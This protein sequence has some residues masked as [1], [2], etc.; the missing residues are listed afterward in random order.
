V[1]QDIVF[2]VGATVSLYADRPIFTV[3]PTYDIDAI[4]EVLTYPEYA[5][6][7]ELIRQH[8]FQNDTTSKVKCRYKLTGDGD[9]EITVDLMPTAD[10]AMGFENIW[11]PDGFKT[12]MNFALDGMSIKILRPEYFLATKFEAFKSRG[13][14][15]PRQSHDFEDIVF[16]LENST[17]IWKEL[18]HAEIQVRD[19]LKLEFKKLLANS[20]IHEWID[21]YVSF[22]SPPPTEYIISELEGL[23]VND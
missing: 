16:V 2:V 20:N 6:F 11:Y 22:A 8:G 23:F 12:A 7:E 13:Y 15:D 21:C 9:E 1:D 19:Y 10:I 17:K 18:R 4:V 3:R 5:K 14:S